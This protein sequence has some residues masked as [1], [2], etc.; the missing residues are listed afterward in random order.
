MS[1]PWRRPQQ[2]RSDLR[3]RLIA[4]L[5]RHLARA[6]TERPPASGGGFFVSQAEYLQ[7]QIDQLTPG[8]RVAISTHELSGDPDLAAFRAAYP[9]EHRCYL[10]P[11]GSLAPIPRINGRYEDL[12]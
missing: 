9:T 10:K 5:R 6:S 1:R 11:D 4:H 3:A 7:D 12:T 2:P 8:T